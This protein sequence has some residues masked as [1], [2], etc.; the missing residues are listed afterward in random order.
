MTD[1]SELEAT[2]GYSFRDKALLER[3]LTH[4][5]LRGV[6]NVSNERLE[7]LGDSVL[8]LSICNYLFKR[9]GDRSEGD[10]SAVKSSAVSRVTLERVARR[11]NLDRFL[12]IEKSLAGTNF[13]PSI[14]AD[15]VEA[16]L[17]AIFVE[18]GFRQAEDVCIRHFEREIDTIV[19]GRHRKNYKSILQNYAQTKLGLETVEY[20]P[21]SESGPSHD[22]RFYLAVFLDGEEYGRGYGKSKK[23]AEQIAAE[24]S[25]H[26]IG[27]GWTPCS[28]NA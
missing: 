14:Y 5:S 21:I 25:M 7:F 18:A 22:K 1:L 6:R 2:L 12:L 8:G 26:M 20:R 23:E 3:A 4:A 24:R 11:L 15:A 28:R 9:F 19:E 10:L 27:A 16:V 17:G 13:S